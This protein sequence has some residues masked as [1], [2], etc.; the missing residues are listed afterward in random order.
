MAKKLMQGVVALT[1]VVAAGCA[2]IIQGSRQQVGVNSV[3]TGAAV[4]IDG[5]PFGGTP[6]VARLER[7]RS[8]IVSISMDGYQPVQLT[9]TRSVSGWLAGNIVFGGLIGVAVDAISGAMYKLNP[10]Q[11][12]ANLVKQGASVDPKNG[13]LYVAVVLRPDASWERIGTL[14]RAE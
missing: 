7:K 1:L 5:A 10:E 11:V 2:T 6:V 14:S 12:A 9:I 3:P 8:H 4:V 13:V